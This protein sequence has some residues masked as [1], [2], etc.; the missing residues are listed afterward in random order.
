MK[1]FTKK[2]FA[3]LMAILMMF[4]L[5]ACGGDKKEE[6]SATGTTNANGELVVGVT[7]FADTL[8]PTEQYFSWVITRYGVGENLVR[9]DENGELQA[10]L[11]EEWKVSDDKLTWEFKIRD[12]VKFSNGNPLTAEAVKSSLER[13]F[14]KSKRADGF[15]KPTSIVADGQTLKISTE[16]PVA[17]LPQCLADP[18]FLIIDTSDNVEEYKYILGLPEWFFYSCVVGLVLIN[19]LVYICIKF[20]FKDIDFDKYNESDKK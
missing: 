15:F 19:I 16:K 17:I 3:F 8:E 1:I 18:L 13:T 4:T 14:R 20:F 12:G 10:L 11:A 6:T 5:V 9:F 7:S 2:S